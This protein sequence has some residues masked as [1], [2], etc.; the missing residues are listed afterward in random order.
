MGDFCTTERISWCNCSICNEKNTQREYMKG[1]KYIIR[2][3][4]PAY[5]QLFFRRLPLSFMSSFVGGLISLNPC[6]KGTTV[7]PIPSKFW[8]IKCCFFTQGLPVISDSCHRFN[9][10]SSCIKPC[11][12]IQRKTIRIRE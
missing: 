9:V 2:K 10:Y 12:L 4:E 5:S 11:D 3:K 7:N 8:V 6:P 1:G